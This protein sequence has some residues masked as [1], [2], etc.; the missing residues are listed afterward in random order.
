MAASRSEVM[1]ATTSIPYPNQRKTANR[2]D[3]DSRS[4]SGDVLSVIGSVLSAGGCE[5]ACRAALVPELRPRIVAWV[6]ESE[7]GTGS[8]TATIPSPSTSM[9]RQR[10][11]LTLAARERN[12]KKWTSPAPDQ[13]RRPGPRSALD[14]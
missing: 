12:A 2:C 6:S 8:N 13:L 14:G 3:S 1:A 10:P 5:R 4:K 9:T 7:S 11:S